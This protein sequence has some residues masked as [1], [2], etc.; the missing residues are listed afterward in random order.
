MIKGQDFIVTSLQS[1]DIAI[2]STIKN[3][4]LEI[5]KNNRVLYL[6][7]PLSYSTRFQANNRPENKYRFDLLKNKSNKLIRQINQNMWVLDCPFC[8][9]PI[10]KIKNQWLFDLLNKINNKR[11][12]KH[13]AKY[14]KTLEFKDPILLI[15]NDIYRSFYLKELLRP[16]ISIYYRRDYVLENPLWVHARRLEYTLA[17]KS[18]I[19]ITNSPHFT[20][21]LKR[22]NP[23]TY[24]TNTGVD[25]SLYNIHKPS[26]LSPS[27]IS[28]ITHPIIGYTGTV[29]NKRINEEFLL[30]LAQKRPNYSIVLV[31]PEDLFFTQSSLH[32]FKNVYFLGTKETQNLPKYISNFDVCINPQKINNITIGNY[33]L[34]ID[35]YLAMGKPI[36]ATRTETMI[37]IFKDYAL[38]AETKEDFINLID[39]ALL[40]NT[41]ESI[42]KR[43]EFAH[44]HTWENSINKI[45]SFIKHYNHA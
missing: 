2:G 1:W 38:L 31:G 45:Y 15:D 26:D 25:L 36:V 23:H 17:Q 40:T 41:P 28:S 37:H 3:T 13:L 33:P 16:K 14:Y 21:E 6:N 34:K 32:H 12:A 22:I 10:G 30:H 27:D 44:T 4:A 39:S 35:E 43:I 42:N 29:T 8:I 20:N 24:T 9:L 11:I 5:S 19:V 7:T 18:N